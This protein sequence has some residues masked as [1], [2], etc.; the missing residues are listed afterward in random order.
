[1]NRILS[2]ATAVFVV[3]GVSAA[4]AD[5]SISGNSRFRYETWADDQE[6]TSDTK[7]NSQF[8]EVLEVWVNADMVADSGLEYGVA[9]RIREKASGF[10]RNYIYLRDDWGQINLGDDWSA[11]YAMSLGADW[12]GT[13]A[14][15]WTNTPAFAGGGSTDATAFAAPKDSYQTTSGKSRKFIYY[16]PN[17]GGF[18]AGVSY[19]DAGSEAKTDSTSYA[20]TYNF[21]LMDGNGVRF[22][23]GAETQSKSNSGADD[24]K[25]VSQYGAEVTMGDLLFSVIRLAD[26]TGETEKGVGTEYEFAYNVSDDTVVN[27]VH[28]NTK[29]DKGNYAGDKYTATQFGVD[30]EAVPGLKFG[31]VH[32][33]FDGSAV[34]ADRPSSDGNA[35]RLQVRLNF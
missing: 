9:V 33:L 2:V 25:T 16:T 15:S 28:L 8:G 35:T 3:G 17:I 12:R 26:E 29:Q 5:I 24:K 4:A 34:N 30:Y 21:D 18:K 23:Y 32:T 31:L 10:D 11:N 7:N 1:M 27:L 20:F 14:G 22:G 13:G 19:A 6:D